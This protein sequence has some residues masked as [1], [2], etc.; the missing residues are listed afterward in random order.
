MQFRNIDLRPVKKQDPKPISGL[1]LL[2]F[3]LT[4]FYM[5]FSWFIYIVELMMFVGVVLESRPSRLARMRWSVHFLHAGQPTYGGD[6]HYLMP[7]FR[8]KDHNLWF[9][10]SLLA[11]GFLINIPTII[12]IKFLR[13]NIKS[14]RDNLWIA[15]LIML[16]IQ[17]L[18][19]I[20]YL[21]GTLTV[22]SDAPE[23]LVFEIL[24]C[25]LGAALDFG[26]MRIAMRL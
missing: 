6:N 11:V 4:G 15:H 12:Y 3:K 20:L 5:I 23:T 21:I 2:F 24:W 13:K 22:Y 9:S 8:S 18:S 19:A 1:W 14:T 16:V 25:L 7:N 17:C 10:I 26:V